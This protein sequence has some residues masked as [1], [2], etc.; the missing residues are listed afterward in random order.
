MVGIGSANC[1][2]VG[3]TTLTILVLITTTPQHQASA[4]NYCNANLMSLM[5]CLTYVQKS[6]PKTP[7]S[8]PCCEAIQPVD[9]SCACGYASSFAERYV[10]LDKVVYV[11][12]SCGKTLVAGTKCGSY[13]IPPPLR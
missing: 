11:A 2:L 8:V 10:S 12:R 7:P 3:L 1:R 5:S 9:V 4:Q 13:T 6:G